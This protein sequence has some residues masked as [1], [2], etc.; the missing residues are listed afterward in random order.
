MIL[1]FIS[2]TPSNV[3]NEIN[4]KIHDLNDIGLPKELEYE[5]E[6]CHHQWKDKFFGFNQSDFF[7]IGS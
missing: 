2:Q 1:E 7:V 5:C 3:V 6:C 4:E